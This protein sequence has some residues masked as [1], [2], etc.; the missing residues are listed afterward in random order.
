MNIVALVPHL[1]VACSCAIGALNSLNTARRF[2]TH[3]SYPNKTSTVLSQETVNEIA[4]VCRVYG[5]YYLESCGILFAGLSTSLRVV[6]GAG[7]SYE[8][9]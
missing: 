3:W 5:C 1:W 2:R 8:L 4:V 6:V 9:L 7:E